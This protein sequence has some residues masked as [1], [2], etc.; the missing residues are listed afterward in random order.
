M[1]E[2]GGERVEEDFDIHEIVQNNKILRHQIQVIKAKLNVES[3]PRFDEVDPN[4][5]IDVT[6]Q[7]E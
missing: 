1:L 3:D 5:I 6:E 4:T 7:A 2:K